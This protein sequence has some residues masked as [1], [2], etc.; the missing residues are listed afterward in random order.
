[1]D[2]PSH[3]VVS[4]CGNPFSINTLALFYLRKCVVLGI[5]ETLRVTCWSF[6][7][8]D[9]DRHVAAL[10]SNMTWSAFFF[11]FDFED[12]PVSG[13]KASRHYQSV[14][15]CQLRKR[16]RAHRGGARRAWGQSC[17]TEQ[18]RWGVW[19]RWRTSQRDTNNN[20]NNKNNV[21]LNKKVITFLDR[22]VLD[23]RLSLLKKLFN[24]PL[25]IARQSVLMRTGTNYS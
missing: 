12:I 13:F 11:F 15:K 14:S 25:L 2:A 22:V 20:N 1:M 5:A 24:Y 23:T 6:Y 19:S 16:L 4:C 10:L 18:E 8:Y 21:A 3:C 9:S 17:P 7:S